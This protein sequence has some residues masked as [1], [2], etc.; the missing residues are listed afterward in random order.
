MSGARATHSPSHSVFPSA[1][2]V[3]RLEVLLLPGSERSVAAAVQAWVT[4]HC[5]V[6]VDPTDPFPTGY[7]VGDIWCE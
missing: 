3:V 1:A 5:T 7:T 6:V 2:T 4:Q